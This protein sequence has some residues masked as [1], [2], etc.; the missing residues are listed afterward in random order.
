MDVVD[1]AGMVVEVI[2]FAFLPDF[3]SIG[4]IH[5]GYVRTCTY[6]TKIQLSVVA[7]FLSRILIRL[8]FEG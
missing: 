2:V 5:L 7:V 4:P 6:I 3:A 8:W 1:L